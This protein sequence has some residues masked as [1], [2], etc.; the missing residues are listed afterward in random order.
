VKSKGDLADNAQNLFN[1]EGMDSSNIKMENVKISN[2]SGDFVINNTPEGVKTEE[3]KEVPVDEVEVEYL[4]PGTGPGFSPDMKAQV[5]R[6]KAQQKLKEDFVSGKIDP[7]D[8]TPEEMEL[9]NS[10]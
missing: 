5:E 1:I 10:N 7:E 3:V 8:L 6:L 2:S 9:L 4:E